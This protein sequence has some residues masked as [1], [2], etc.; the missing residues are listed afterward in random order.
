[1]GFEDCQYPREK[2][3]QGE[4]IMVEKN[5][6]EYVKKLF[7]FLKGSDDFNLNIRELEKPKLS[8]EQ[9]W[10][11]IYVLQEIR[12][13]GIHNLPD[14]I[15][16]CSQCNELYDS[17]NE[18]QH[19]DETHLDDLS[20]HNFNESDVG[21][22]FCEMCFDRIYYRGVRIKKDSNNL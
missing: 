17:D 13:P 19:I 7:R 11:V 8:P 16:M 21:Y 3:N 5:E 1:M 14:T 22:N 18:G 20:E 12:E 2:E 4:I 10:T 15:E 9:A 6:L